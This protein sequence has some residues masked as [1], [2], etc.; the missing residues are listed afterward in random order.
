MTL[1]QNE[2]ESLAAMNTTENN[3]FAQETV[4]EAIERK[5]LSGTFN[6]YVRE[7]IREIPELT[8]HFA[9]VNIAEEKVHMSI[10]PAKAGFDN[11]RDLH[12][13]LDNIMSAYAP[14]QTSVAHFDGKHNLSLL[15]YNGPKH[16]QMFAD[17]VHDNLKNI[18]GIMDHELGHMVVEG[19]YY[20][21]D[22]FSKTDI[23]FAET[24]ADVFAG[25]RHLSRFMGKA[26]DIETLSWQRAKDLIETGSVSHFTSFGLD[27]L[28][29]L[30]QENDLSGIKGEAAARLA[31]RIASEA[32]PHETVVN[33]IARSLSGI[34]PQDFKTKTAEDA[35]RPLAEKILSGELGYFTGKVADKYIAPYLMEQVIMDGKNPVL[36][37]GPYW[38]KV[39]IALFD[40]NEK[41]QSQGLLHGMNAKPKTP[42]R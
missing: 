6:A 7:T 13:Y 23:I 10:D 12:D 37:N 2:R 26:E 27:K 21:A 9:I 34:T 36:L 35:L 31:H 33:N 30:A 32:A 8:G 18:V 16:M 42:G 39:R 5:S 17:P 28:A 15:V 11:V 25:L 29:E 20:Y 22:R 40:M 3:A 4:V 41:S 24:G 14:I 38:D 19:A 1:F